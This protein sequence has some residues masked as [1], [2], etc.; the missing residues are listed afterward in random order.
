[1]SVIDEI[2]VSLVK[3]RVLG[4]GLLF[5]AIFGGIV[6]V[7]YPELFDVIRDKPKELE[8]GGVKAE[9]TVMPL[10]FVMLLSVV[11]AFIV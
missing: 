3:Y 7:F 9:T 1:M 11:G 10:W 6:F 2:L 4:S 5:L 8:I